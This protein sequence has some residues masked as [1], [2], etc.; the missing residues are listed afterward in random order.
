[1]G[2]VGIITLWAITLVLWRERE[3]ERERERERER[4]K[5]RCQSSHE[6]TNPLYERQN[7]I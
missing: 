7:G 1:M 4:E 3:G 6:K 5:E 2:S